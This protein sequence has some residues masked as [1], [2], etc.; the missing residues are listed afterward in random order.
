MKPRREKQ[1]A[2]CHGDSRFLGAKAGKTKKKKIS[3]AKVWKR[4]GNTVSLGTTGTKVALLARAVFHGLTLGDC[5]LCG[6]SPPLSHL[7]PSSPRG[8]ALTS[9]L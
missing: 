2:A 7:Q 5:K 4:A 1:K 3:L 8:A 9:Q 6:L